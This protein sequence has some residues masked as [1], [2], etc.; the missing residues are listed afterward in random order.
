MSDPTCGANDWGSKPA[1]QGNESI[2]IYVAE[3]ACRRHSEERCW[4]ACSRPRW[5]NLA[6]SAGLD[7]CGRSG[8]FRGNRSSTERG[9]LEESMSRL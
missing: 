9:R 5:R 8:A 2:L 7:D 3:G 6:E 1:S 4:T